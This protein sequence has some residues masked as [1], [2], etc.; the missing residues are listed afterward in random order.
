MKLQLL[1][2]CPS[3]RSARNPPFFAG[4]QNDEELREEEEEEGLETEFAKKPRL[5]MERR[6]GGREGESGEW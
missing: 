3:S 1:S 6:E 5:D 4:G 2:I